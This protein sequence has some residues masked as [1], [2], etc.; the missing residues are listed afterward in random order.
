M[1]LKLPQTV[2]WRNLLDASDI[3][4]FA[5]WSSLASEPNAVHEEVTTTHEQRPARNLS[6]GPGVFDI[7]D[8]MDY[9]DNQEHHHYHKKRYYLIDLDELFQSG[10][11]G[12]SCI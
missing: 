5:H 12:L 3:V 2:A 4:I 7:S 6:F 11:T 1:A 10:L 9:T 8:C